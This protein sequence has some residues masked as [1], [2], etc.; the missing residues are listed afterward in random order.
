V[1]L[2]TIW[3]AAQAGTGY[4]AKAEEWKAKLAAM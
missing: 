3:H 2:Y 1:D 4:D